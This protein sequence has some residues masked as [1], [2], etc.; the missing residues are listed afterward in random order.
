MRSSDCT[1]CMYK[2]HPDTGW[3]YM[4]RNKPSGVCSQYKKQIKI[5]TKK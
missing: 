1:K 4:F 3:C 2:N 5:I